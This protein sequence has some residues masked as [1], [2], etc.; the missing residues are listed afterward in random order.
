MEYTKEEI[1][2]NIKTHLK[3]IEDIKI[4]RSVLRVEMKSAKEQLLI[5]EKLDKRQ[6]KMF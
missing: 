1:E 2:L 5:W 6:L 4:K 3:S